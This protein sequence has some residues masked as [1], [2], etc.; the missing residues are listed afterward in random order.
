MADLYRRYMAGDG[1]EKNEETATTWFANAIA[2]GHA[3]SMIE[4]SN[5]IFQDPNDK[6]ALFGLNLAER[7]AKQGHPKGFALA[8]AFYSSGRINGRKDNAQ[9]VAWAERGVAAGSMQAA[10]MLAAHYQYGEGVEQNYAKARQ[11]YALAASEVQTAKLEYAKLLLQGRGG[12]KDEDGAIGLLTDLASKGYSRANYPL[13]IALFQSKTNKS[14][15]GIKWLE[16]C[17]QKD[18]SQCLMAIASM[19]YLGEKVLPDYLK[20]GNYAKQAAMKGHRDGMFLMGIMIKDGQLPEKNASIAYAWLSLAAVRDVELALKNRQ[21]LEYTMRTE[22][23]L[24]GQK[25]A[26][27]WEPGKDITLPRKK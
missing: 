10:A 6:E 11:Y 13:G 2:A 7:A 16:H 5:S 19:Y 22:E 9:A 25:L 21:K 26:S 15:D 17:D 3:D 4:L 27:E 1:V 23:I 14:L 20:A 12:D 8:S 18:E 24:L